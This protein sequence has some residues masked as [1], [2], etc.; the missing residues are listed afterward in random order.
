MRTAI[1][2]LT[3]IIAGA[4]PAR[5]EVRCPAD[6]VRCDLENPQSPW[7]L[8]YVSGVVDEQARNATRET[9]GGVDWL[10]ITFAEGWK[11]CLSPGMSTAPGNYLVPVR[12]Y[13]ALHPD[14][15][16]ARFVDV[17]PAALSRAFPCTDTASMLRSAPT[18][19]YLGEALKLKAAPAPQR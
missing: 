17:L 9:M 6:L 12:E 2:A 8:G 4:M 11:T 14:V 19:D 5:A 1:V 7:V 16:A 15:M 3:A 10:V 13:V 18:E